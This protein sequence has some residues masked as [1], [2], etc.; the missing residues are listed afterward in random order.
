MRIFDIFFSFSLFANAMLFIPQI[1]SILKNK[2]Q[3]GISIF[4]FSGFLIIQASIVLNGLIK[5]DYILA[6][7]TA[8]SL[9][10]CGTVVILILYYRK[11]ENLS[12]P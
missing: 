12:K 3:K 10:T 11:K 6:F 9:I 4:T 7:G 5:N 1:I 8:L 2:S